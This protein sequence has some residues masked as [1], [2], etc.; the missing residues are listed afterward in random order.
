VENPSFLMMMVISETAKLDS[1]HRQR[2][3]PKM[4]AGRF[5]QTNKKGRNNQATPHQFN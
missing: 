4:T 2:C 1:V 5:H 3:C